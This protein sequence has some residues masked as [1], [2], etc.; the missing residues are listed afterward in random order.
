MGIF[1]GIDFNNLPKHFKEDSVREDDCDMNLLEDVFNQIKDSHKKESVRSKLTNYPFH[2]ATKTAEDSF[3]LSFTAR[4]SND[5]H[6]NKN[7]YYLPFHVET[8]IK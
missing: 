1:D 3:S 4:L 6:K 2:Y 7:E 5:F 8:F